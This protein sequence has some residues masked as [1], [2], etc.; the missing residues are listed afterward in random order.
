[1]QYQH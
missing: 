1:M